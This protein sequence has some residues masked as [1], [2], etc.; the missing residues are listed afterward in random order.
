MKRCRLLLIDS[1]SQVCLGDEKGVS[2]GGRGAHPCIHNN[3]S[4]KKYCRDFEKASSL[5]E[6]SRSSTTILPEKNLVEISRKQAVF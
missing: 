3:F 5:V 1:Q 4:R 2:R 6:V